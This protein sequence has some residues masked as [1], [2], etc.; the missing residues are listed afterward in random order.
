VTREQVVEAFG[1][2][3]S[4][5]DFSERT[6]GMNWRLWGRG[7]IAA[8]FSTVANSVTVIVVDPTTFNLF[9]GGAAKL[10]QVALVSAL[11]GAALYLKEH[12]D[13]WKD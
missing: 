4:V 1:G 5:Y 6:I 11:V 12:P 13:P 10:G 9:Q 8:I 7:L 2:T 3:F